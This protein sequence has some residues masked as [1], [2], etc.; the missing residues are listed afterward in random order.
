MPFFH[1]SLRITR[2][3]FLDGAALAVAGLSPAKLFALAPARETD[4]SA[5]SGWRGS[6]AASYAIAHGVRDG[7]RYSIDALPIEE[8][9]DLI[10][11]G[12]GIGGLAAAYFFRRQHPR[13]RVL[14]LENHD[15]FG[16]H[17]RRNEFTIDGRRLISY[18]GSE[19]IQS[20]A[21]Q[22]SAEALDLLRG[23]HV[24]V[25]R[26]ES[27]F[28]RTLY[29]DLG[30]ARGIFFNR[31]AFGV[32][33]LVVGD[34]TPRFAD[35]IAADRLNARPITQF[36]ADF[37]LSA[38]QKAKLAALFTEARDALADHDMKQRATVL[39]AT[40]YRDFIQRYWQLDDRTANVLQSR[41]NDFFAVGT[42]ILPA[43]DAME[44][45]FPGFQGVRLARGTAATQANDPYIHHFPDGNA[46]L[47]RLLVRHLIPSVAPGSSMDDIVLAQFDYTRLDQ[48]AAAVRLRL[49][50]TA[51][52]LRNRD[53]GRVD[54]GYVRAG[55][56]HRVQAA[57]VV[58]SGYAAMLPYMCPDIGAAQRAA[59]AAAVKGPL[60]YAKV[61]VRNWQA[62]VKRGVHDIANPMGFFCRVKLDY[63]V[64]LGGYRFP[65]RPDEPMVLHMVHV[66][67]APARAGL[68]Q[69]AAWKAARSLL[70]ELTF[71]D[72]ERRIRDELTRMLGAGGFDAARDIRAITVNRWGH[73]YSYGFNSLYDED[74]QFGSQLLSRRSVGR[75]GIAGADAA[76]SAYA[77]AAIDQA[78]RAVA[79]IAEAGR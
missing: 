37:P 15:D 56:L 28:H 64:S 34:P 36:I 70:Y 38:E 18:G 65:T 29:P 75:I 39:A 49:G 35:E 77:H 60:V 1:M 27:A 68:D 21:R 26:F 33:K 14:I 46:S 16:G 13:A 47:A 63:P 61:L 7:R 62:W 69:R 23:L 10:V 67:A 54:V 9:Y 25:D 32:D 74:H 11:I 59:L 3:D 2:R 78:H 72:F 52:M 22:W 66:S 30:L 20:P 76:W 71:E 58:Y 6:T 48:S 73:G 12:G 31:E 40:S 8:N 57:H 5:L 17:A 53:N 45:G 50:S 79:E 19:S 43:Y 41:S 51:V 44:A 24:D 55:A 4:P 42:Q